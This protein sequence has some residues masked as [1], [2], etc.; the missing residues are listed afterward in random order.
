MEALVAVALASIVVQFVDFAIRVTSK[1]RQIYR[2]GATIEHQ[3]LDMLSSK[4][5][6]ICGEVEKSIREPGVSMASTHTETDLVSLA[7]RCVKN[8]SNLKNEL[9]QIAKHGDKGFLASV[10]KPVETMRRSRAIN[11]LRTRLERDQSLLDTSILLSLKK[12]AREVVD[13][14]HDLEV[15]L[16]ENTTA[17]VQKLAYGFCNI[18]SL[19]ESQAEATVAK[20]REE[21]EMTRNHIS[22]KFQDFQMNSSTQEQR[23]ALVKSLHFPEI[24][25]RQQYICKAHAKTFRFLFDESH[26]R[27]QSWL[28]FLRSEGGIFWLSGKLGSG[29]TVAMNLIAG[30]HCIKSLLFSE[31][32]D[33]AEPLI[34]T[35]FAWNTGS[36]LQNSACGL[37]RSILHQLLKSDERLIDQVFARNQTL[38]NHRLVE[39]WSEEKLEQ[40]LEVT[41]S[42]LQRP[43]FVLVDGVDEF[44][45]EPK[46]IVNIVEL[47]TSTAN[48]KICV[49][50]RPWLRL[51]ERLK[52]EF[53]KLQDLTHHSIRRYVT[54]RLGNNFDYQALLEGASSLSADAGSD[55]VEDILKKACGVFLW[56]RLAVDQILEGIG[57]LDDWSTLVQRLKE[58]P[59]EMEQVYEKMWKSLDESR[60]RVYRDEA[61][62][63]FAI[64]LKREMSL[65]EFM[66]TM[67]RNLQTMDFKQVKRLPLAKLIQKCHDK[68]VHIQVRS[69]GFLEVSKAA[70]ELD[71]LDPLAEDLPVKDEAHFSVDELL[72]V[73]HQRYTVGFL[74]RTAADFVRE[75]TRNSMLL[76]QD[77]ENDE[78][79][80][81]VQSTHLRCL[82][83]LLDSVPT[84]F[85]LVEEFYVIA[86]ACRRRGR[87]PVKCLE[88]IEHVITQ[89]L[90]TEISTLIAGRCHIAYDMVGAVLESS[91]LTDPLDHIFEVALPDAGYM[92]YL[93]ACYSST[94][95]RYEGGAAAS[96]VETMIEKGAQP[97]KPPNLPSWRPRLL[98]QDIPPC[99]LLVQLFLARF[100]L[101]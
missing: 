78:N 86:Q 83:W 15:I 5:T 50:G 32:S 70:R 63:Y 99:H 16:G 47:M 6:T 28:R 41:I 69:V 8:A 33:K 37:L 49:S 73:Q 19:V 76:P 67:D 51:N 39:E 57:N 9:N 7:Q 20:V 53:L 74:H 82:L 43:L 79:A 48:V 46:I 96:V 101:V 71:E 75:K 92:T 91:Y 89:A 34:V 2:D 4:L 58:I 66:T 31:K 94:L 90:N 29:K 56:V 65:L 60:N 72:R 84:G 81:V 21:G 61:M 85:T 12:T 100:V 45:D 3:E 44:K 95:P 35:F 11:E 30:N 18:R 80:K 17:I 27:M 98:V 36:T 42:S 77:Q 87:V 64:I 40:L 88:L 59:D 13:H 68:R 93:L 62:Q 52:C 23:Q 10:R 22:Q 25:L 26:P 38:F 24:N 97:M 54:D 55:L 14:H 1:C